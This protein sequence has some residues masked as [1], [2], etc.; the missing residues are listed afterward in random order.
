MTL[1]TELRAPKPRRRK[2]INTISH[3]LPTKHAQLEHLFWSK[4]R[5]ELWIE[6]FADWFSTEV[7]VVRLHQI[8]NFDASLFHQVRYRTLSA[9]KVRSRRVRADEDYHRLRA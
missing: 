1:R 2:L 3:I 9:T 8:V 4:L 7:D 6:V 5:L